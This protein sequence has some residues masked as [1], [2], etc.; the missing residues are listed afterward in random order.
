MKTQTNTNAR[1][2]TSAKPSTGEITSESKPGPNLSAKSGGT[3]HN[4]SVGVKNDSVIST[5]AA[6]TQRRK[7]KAGAAKTKETKKKEPK[8]VEP[9]RYDFVDSYRGS[10][11]TLV[12]NATQK[13]RRRWITLTEWPASLV[14]AYDAGILTGEAE[15]LA[16][17]I[18]AMVNHPWKTAFK[19]YRKPTEA[20]RL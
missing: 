17:G 9:L 11:T 12:N 15:V 20:T 4:E 18:K 7:I 1:R 2:R 16:R 6:P 8:P 3:N 5:D 13:T 10:M 19:Y 14:Q